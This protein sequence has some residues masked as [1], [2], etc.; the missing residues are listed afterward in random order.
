MRSILPFSLRRLAAALALGAMLS[1]A[2][3]VPVMDM[4]AEDF[5][6][7]A[8]DLK[9]QLKLN[10]NQQT[11]WQQTESRTRNLL[12]ER[13]SRRERLQAAALTAAQTPGVEL[14]DVAR[15]VE[16]ESITAAGEEKQLREW[17]LIVNDALDET[18]RGIVAQQLNEHLLRVQDSGGPGPGRGE[19]RDDGGEHRGGGRKGGGQ[20]GM[21]IGV[22]AGGASMSLPGG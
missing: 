19:R 6:P 14:R 13:K 18:Q 10:A 17:W 3:A 7:L 4:R 21:G 8:A 1:P 5:L 16:A 9:Q 2:F 12:R 11:L 22:G 15:T 20:G